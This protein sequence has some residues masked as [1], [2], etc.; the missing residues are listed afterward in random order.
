M[1]RSG[2]P[3]SYP[4]TITVTL[5]MPLN[6]NR[7]LILLALCQTRLTKWL[8]YK[9]NERFL[10]HNNFTCVKV[11][12]LIEH[13]SWR[14]KKT[15]LNFGLQILNSQVFW[16]FVFVFTRTEVG[17]K[18]RGKATKFENSFNTILKFTLFKWHKQFLLFIFHKK[19]RRF[20]KR[21]KKIF[22]FTG[23]TS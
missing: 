16:C 23:L 2:S 17:K 5:D 4:T 7:Y 20:K 12:A 18:N 10:L 9:E 19:L 13:F 22:I 11:F 6:L 14:E 3:I 8:L 15:N 21:G 1:K